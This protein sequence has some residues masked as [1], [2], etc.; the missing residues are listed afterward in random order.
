MILLN[1]W[2]NILIT[3]L[4]SP[5]VFEILKLFCSWL[6]NKLKNRSLPYTISGYWL[7]CHNTEVVV[8]NIAYTACEI[9]KI[10]QNGTNLSFVLYQLTNDKRFYIYRGVGYIRG[11][12]VSLSYE[13]THSEISSNTGSFTLLK[14]D[15]LQHTSCFTGIYSEF[16]KEEKHCTSMPYS[17]HLL[18]L[19]YFE[20]IMFTLFKSKYAKQ[21]MKKRNFFEQHENNMQ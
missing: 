15:T 5:A 1:D 12:K 14:R 9:I 18:K 11:S 13:E 17:M 19:T 8:E 3:S 21:Y 20:R 16:V 4:I 6:Y 2:I 7:A 10:K